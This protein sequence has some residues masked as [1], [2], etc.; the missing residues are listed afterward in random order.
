[1]SA[2]YRDRYP[3]RK[4]SEG[5]VVYMGKRGPKPR[6]WGCILQSIIVGTLIVAV[7]TNWN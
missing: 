1:M 4:V 7:L 3:K 2:M 5:G 6:S